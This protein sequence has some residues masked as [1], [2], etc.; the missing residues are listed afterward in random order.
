MSDLERVARL[1]NKHARRF[2]ERDV[3]SKDRLCT[4]FS[5]PDFDLSTST[6]LV[7]DSADA[8]VAVA[9]VFHHDPH[10]TVQV[11]CPVDAAHQGRGIGRFLHDWILERSREAARQASPDTRVVLRQQTYDGD[12]SAEAFLRQAGYHETRHYWRMRIEFDGPPPPPQWPER[13]V[14]D[15]FDPKRDLEASA[16]ASR[17]AF[18]DHYGFVASSLETELERTR[19]Y[20]ETDPDFDP[21][22]WFLARD[23]DQVAGLCLCSPKAAGEH[24]TAYVQNLG[25]R[26]AWRRRGLGRTLLLHAFG[27]LYRRG[28]RAVALHV[29]AQSL[30]GATR[31]YESV[32]MKVDDLSHE[33]E[34]ELRAG[35]DLTV[36][37]LRADTR[38]T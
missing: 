2:T 20:I 26:P 33:Y 36:K 4:M 9:I 24:T 17:E 15:T 28:K 21:T 12:A 37:E 38:R 19:H 7:L 22:L 25:V 23:G 3:V 27:E 13:I 10:V 14:P 16:R 34:L 18:Q 6:R 32:G 30:T 35:V 8:P 1:A 5:A 11:W 29:D 31:L